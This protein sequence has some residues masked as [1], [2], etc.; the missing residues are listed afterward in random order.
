M[1]N[2]GK[3]YESHFWCRFPVIAPEIV[4]YISMKQ[5]LRDCGI[6]QIVVGGSRVLV[7]TMILVSCKYSRIYSTGGFCLHNLY[8]S[9]CIHCSLSSSAQKVSSTP[10]I[11]LCYSLWSS[12]ASCYKWILASFLGRR[13]ESTA[14]G[15]QYNCLRTCLN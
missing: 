5:N 11:K 10:N 15:G 7:E 1:I 9:G 3:V 4:V 2:I 13:P 12:S 6:D 8:Y 14:N